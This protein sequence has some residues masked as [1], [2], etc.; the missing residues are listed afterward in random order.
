M[1]TTV[2]DPDSQHLPDQNQDL[3]FYHNRI[4]IRVFIINVFVKL[5][6]Y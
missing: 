4:W 3:H 1:E 2:A 5:P 6:K